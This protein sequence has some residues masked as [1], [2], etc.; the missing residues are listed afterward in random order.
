MD[1]N[2]FVMEYF[3]NVWDMLARQGSCD[4]RPGK[5]YIRV[6]GEWNFAGRPK[7][8]VRFIGEACN[9]HKQGETNETADK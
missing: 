4:L 2:A 7:P 3:D 9:R 8:L 6:W 1:E 5:E